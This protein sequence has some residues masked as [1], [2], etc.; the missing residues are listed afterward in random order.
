VT[1]VAY[2]VYGAIGLFICNPHVCVC[3]CVCV[4]MCVYVYVCVCVCVCVLTHVGMCFAGGGQRPRDP[5]P[6]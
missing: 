5:V 6:S 1:V 3:V 2:T 4:C